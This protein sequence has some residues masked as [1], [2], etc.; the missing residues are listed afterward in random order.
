[1]RHAQ[2]SGTKP[3]DATLT[4][5]DRHV[6]PEVCHACGHDVWQRSSQLV[7]RRIEVSVRHTTHNTR[8][9]THNTQHEPD[10]VTAQHT[11]VSRVNC[12]S[13]CSVMH[14]HWATYVSC[15]KALMPTGM[16]P[17]RRWW[18]KLTCVS[19]PQAIVATAPHHHHH[20]RHTHQT[21]TSVTKWPVNMHTGSWI[22]VSSSSTA[23]HHHPH[24]QLLTLTTHQ[25][26]LLSHSPAVGS[27]VGSQTQG[28]CPRCCS[29]TSTAACSTI[30][31]TPTT[32]RTAHDTL[33]EPGLQ[34]TTTPWRCW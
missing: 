34:H 21:P 8:H 6:S 24:A 13:A 16:V 25:H 28:S 5:P 22:Q 1:M 9:T 14:H 20:H 19:R 30:T 3:Y 27:Q 4:S 33:R 26:W 23:P 10:P 2:S 15:D 11:H 12:M 17:S 7:V 18:A 32:S 31:I 29:L